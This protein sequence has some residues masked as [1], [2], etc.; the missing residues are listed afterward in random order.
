MTTGPN[1]LAAKWRAEEASGG[2]LAGR[3]ATIV[4]LHGLYQHLGVSRQAK[5]DRHLS[6]KAWLETKPE[7][8]PSLADQI[9]RVGL[10]VE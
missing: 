2:A 7:L 8:T 1:R 9:R 4:S 10:H 5:E 6:V 3:S